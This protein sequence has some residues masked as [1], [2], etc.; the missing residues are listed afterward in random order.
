RSAGH[1][2]IV[3]GIC[4]AAGFVLFSFL[5]K[6]QPW[7]SRLQLPFFILGAAFAGVVLD[8]ALPRWL[9]SMLLVVLTASALPYVLANALR[10]LIGSESVL[11]SDRISQYFKSRPD[12]ARPYAAAAD[13]VRDTRCTAVG[14]MM[15]AD[16]WEYPF[17][18]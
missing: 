9:G 17:W 14:L 13:L 2:T 8:R 11:G 1:R 7:H 6:W 10:P 5:L 18:V 16:D 4:V 15:G 3:F 12:L